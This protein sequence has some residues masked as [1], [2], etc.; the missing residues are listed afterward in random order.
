MNLTEQEE[1]EYLNQILVKIDNS[2]QIINERVGDQLQDINAAKNHLQEHKRDMDHLEKNAIREAVGQIA[3]MGEAAVD[4]KRRLHRLRD[5]PYF[6]RIDFAKVG[7][8]LET[9]YIGVHNFRDENANQNLVYD[10][11]APISSMFYDFELGDA[12]FENLSGK[13]NGKISKKRQYRIR[14]GKMDYMLDTNLTIQDDVLQRELNQASTAKMKNIVATIQREQ[15][16]IIRNV[17]ARNLIIQGVAGSG[18]TSIALHRIAFLLYK[19]KQTI[20]SEDILIISPNKVF[21]SYISNVLPEL[22]EESV[23]ETSMEELARELLEYKVEFQTFFHQV[24]E[25]LTG[26]DEQY[27]HRIRFKSTGDLLKKMDEYLIHLEN[28]MFQAKDL[29]VGKTPVPAW[30]IEEKFKKYIRLPLLKRFNE[31]VRDIVDNMYIHYGIEVTGAERTKL[32]SAVRKMFPSANI[33][34]LYKGFYQWLERPELLK[35]KK[36]SHYEYADVFPMIYLKSKL[37]GL[38][39]YY[40]IKHLIVDEMQDYSP[41]QYYILSQLFPCKKTILGDINQSVNP[42]SSSNLESIKAIFPGS[43]SMTM[44]KSYRSTYEITEFTKE[45]G[46]NVKVEAIARHGE[47]PQ[48]FEFHSKNEEMGFILRSVN[49]FRGSSHN[50]MGIV[51]KTQQ[52]ADELYLEIKREGGA[53]NLLDARTVA[54]SGGLAVT[55]SHLAK[56]LEFD[57]VLVPFANSQMYNSIADRQMLY[58]ACTRAMHELKLSYTGELT[59]LIPQSDS[60][61]KI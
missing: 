55:T 3:M 39:P 8:D 1:K 57:R 7:K 33:R 54:F 11:R 36:G 14:R 12:Y 25:L 40:K 18:K 4:K 41:V 48:V 61:E 30:F 22:G 42:F 5:I 20:S 37:E 44:L 21:A 35:I 52:Q 56:G 31:V 53:V 28:H 17:D 27:V 46:L 10:W 16:A 19:F 13:V 23:A 38:Q 60:W 59:T 29:V 51:C 9:I 6:G 2:I 26:R 15:N 24:A 47:K 45:I 58:V 32:H 49:E 50:S 43:E 34:M